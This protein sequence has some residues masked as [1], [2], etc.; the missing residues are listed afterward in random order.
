MLRVWRRSE[1][2]LL[3][4]CRN[5]PQAGLGLSLPEGMAYRDHYI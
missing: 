3:C 1:A 2:Q 4:P 5:V